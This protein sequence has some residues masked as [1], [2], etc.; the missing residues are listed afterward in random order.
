MLPYTTKSSKKETLDKSRYWYDLASAVVHK[1]KLDAG[2]YYVYCRQGD[3]VSGGKHVL[4]LIRFHVWDLLTPFNNDPV[5]V[6]QWWPS[7]CGV[8]IRSSCSRCIS[9]ILH[10]SIACVNTNTTS[11]LFQVLA[12]LVQ[13]RHQQ[14]LFEKACT[15]GI[16]ALILHVPCFLWNKYS[17]LLSFCMALRVIDHGSLYSFLFLSRFRARSPCV[18]RGK[19]TGV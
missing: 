17:Y 4:S 10:T 19:E 13:D 6:I 9:F 12:W 14:K 11:H 5:D 2:H 8:R 15:Q 18:P 3:Q 7:D 16:P 1:G